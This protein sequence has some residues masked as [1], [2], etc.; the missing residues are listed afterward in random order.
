DGA[1]IST[2]LVDRAVNE[3]LRVRLSAGWIDWRPVEREFHQVVGLDAL[4]RAGAGQN[5]PIGAIRMAD[6]DMAE[7]VDDALA[8]EDAVGR[9]ELVE[10]R[11]RC[12]HRRCKIT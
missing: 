12:S 2:H 6:A 1:H 3:P 5:I 4:R 8:R 9:D 10:R 11:S 7:G